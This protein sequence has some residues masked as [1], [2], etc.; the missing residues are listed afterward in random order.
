MVERRMPRKKQEDENQIEMV[1]MQNDKGEG[2]A[3]LVIFPKVPAQAVKTKDNVSNFI[4]HNILDAGEQLL[5]LEKK[6]RIRQ[7]I[8]TKIN[9][10]YEGIDIQAKKEFTLFDQAV[11]DAIVSLYLADNR[12]VSP[13]MVYR[14]MTGKTNAEYINPEKLEEIEA[15]IDK[16]MFSRLS[17]DASEEAAAYGYQQ[18]IYS[19]TLLSAEKVAVKMGGCRI[20]AYNIT[21]EPLLY[22]YAKVGKQI[23]AIDI[24]LLDTPIKKTSDNI[25]L[26][27]FILR[28]IEAMKSDRNYSRMVIFSDIYNI[29]NISTAQRV[30]A[31]RIRDYVT[32]ILDY[33]VEKRYIGNYEIVKK[34]KSIYGITFFLQ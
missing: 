6:G 11:Y 25:I 28:K 15:S 10:S 32:E 7:E 26:Q 24:K 5:E 34:G 22:R 14:T 30:Q 27:E 18:A 33:W 17:I 12:F 2:P 29:L 20:I 23:T 4:T 21:T 16:C 3:E 1:V 8:K 31:K 19:G 13:A 9:F